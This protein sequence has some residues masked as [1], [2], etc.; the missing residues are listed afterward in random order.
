MAD[1]IRTDVAI[2]SSFTATNADDAV[3][4]IICPDA[5][6]N[7]YKTGGD[8]TTAAGNDKGAGYVLC[9]DDA[10]RTRFTIV[11]FGVVDDVT[12]KDAI[13]VSADGI[14]LSF[15]ASGDI[16]KWTAG[17]NKIGQL[18]DI[19]DVSAGAPARVFFNFNLS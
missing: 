12:I 9:V 15:D 5:G 14:Y 2:P 11:T 13:D 4:R 8:A 1:Q 19:A 18:V 16:V 6:N 7:A 3:G 17:E 10:S